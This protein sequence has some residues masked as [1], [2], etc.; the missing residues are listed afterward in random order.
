MST[1]NV[2]YI[3]YY[4]YTVEADCED[5][6]ESLAYDMFKSDMMYPVANTFYDDIEIEC[7]DDD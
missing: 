3:Q 2:T 7:T 4:H 5:E 6:A 1:Y